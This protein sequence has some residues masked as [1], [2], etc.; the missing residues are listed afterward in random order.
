YAVIRHNDVFS[1]A[2]CLSSTI[3]PCMEDFIED[4]GAAYI[5]PDTRVYLS[6]GT[7]EGGGTKEYP[8][9]DTS[10]EMERRNTTLAGL[11]ADRGALSRTYKQIGGY[12]CEA[13]WEKQVP[14]FMPYL[15]QNA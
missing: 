5:H 2:A 8:R 1:K 12:H 15:W 4:I 9:F 7:E 10:S 14:V 13:D 6:W 3:A 11:I